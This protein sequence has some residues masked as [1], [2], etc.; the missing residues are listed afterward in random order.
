M[1]KLSH[2]LHNGADYIK[3]S[4][5]MYRPFFVLFEI[6]TGEIQA[7]SEKSGSLNVYWW[8]NVTIGQRFQRINVLFSGNF[9]MID[10]F[11]GM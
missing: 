7:K 10:R 11:I 6:I 2:R 3:E 9:V 5:G 8:E 1:L 4:K